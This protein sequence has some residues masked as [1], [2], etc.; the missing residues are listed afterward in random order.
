MS[1]EES[2]ARTWLEREDIACREDRLVRV[3]WLTKLAPPVEYLTFPGGWIAKH[4]Y[5]EGRYCFAYGQFMA[6]IVLGMAYIEHTLAALFFAAGRSDMER[7]NIS[8][9]LTEAVALGWLSQDEFDNLDRARSLRNPIAHFR[10]PLHE[11]TVE[12]GCVSESEMP[13]SIL[14][15]DARHVMRAVLRLLARN[16]A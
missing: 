3:S 6:A 14:E 11:D 12:H 4:L 7:A 8:A 5:E 16:A 10:R 9:L 13:Y 1:I 15:E 2:E